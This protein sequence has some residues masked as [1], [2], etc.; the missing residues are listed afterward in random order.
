MDSTLRGPTPSKYI[1][2]HL[3][4]A[5]QQEARRRT[6]HGARPPLRLELR[7]RLDGEHRAR[8][9]ARVPLRLWPRAVRRQ[10]DAD[11]LRV[12]SAA[13]RHGVAATTSI[14]THGSK[15]VNP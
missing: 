10:C 9:D 4:V 8:D 13:G 14:I 11:A 1:D 7:A 15:R 3:L 2:R 12:R 5:E 6:P